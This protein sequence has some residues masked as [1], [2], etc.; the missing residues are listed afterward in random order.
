MKQDELQVATMYLEGTSLVKIADATG[1]TS[2][3]VSKML[4]SDTVKVYL[5]EQSDRLKLTTEMR[6]I[7][8][9]N[10]IIEDRINELTADSFAGLSDKDT[11]DIMKALVPI[12]RHN[13]KPN[14]GTAVQ[15]NTTVNI[16]ESPR[17]GLHQVAS[18]INDYQDKV[19][20]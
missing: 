11:V 3:Q 4:K 9:G 17:G 12:V 16:Q 10:K 19:D 6:I 5:T 15:T 20:D 2:T 1:L 13:S 14:V 18:F 8:V 7:Q